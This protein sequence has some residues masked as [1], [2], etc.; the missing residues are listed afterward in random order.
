LH[1]AE[2]FPNF[3]P[4][5]H[6]EDFMP[7]T[8]G[9]FRVRTMNK[10]SA[11]GLSLFGKEYAV[12]DIEENP[13]ALLV[14]S[15]KVDVAEHAG[16]AAVARAGAGVN[17]INVDKATELGVCVFNTPGAN[18]NAVN[19]LVFA[20]LSMVSRNLYQALDYVS[21]LKDWT[22]DEA[23]DKEVEKNKARFAG[24]EL[25]GRTMAIVGLGKIGVLVAN[26]AVAR[27][28]KVLA[29][30]P[31]PSP[32]NMHALHQ[33]VQVFTDLEAILPTADFVSVHVP[34]FDST[35]GLF[36]SS[37]IS[38]MKDDAILLN[39]SRGPVVDTESVVASLDSGKL[40]AYICDFPSNRLLNHDKVLCFP[41]L[42]ASTEEAEENCA[43]MA[44]EQLKDYLHF[45]CVRNS[46]NFPAIEGR[47]GPKI[48]TRL[49]VINKDVPNMIS[50]ISHVIAQAGI[51]IASYKNES[52]GKVGYNLIDLEVAMDDALVSALE[53]HANI[54]KVR[55]LKF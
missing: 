40:A 46:V 38:E 23:L 19:E 39:F 22:D 10:I 15:A 13:H 7:H 12:S 17:N 51:N 24:I 8:T 27:G 4:F 20:T 48:K 14:R 2:L 43:T 29:Y 33:D 41:H 35:R 9:T 44:V 3:T 42:G 32:W 11:K 50:E 16:L 37:L 47:P 53:A 34:L 21:T 1:S 28:L 45:G 30:E 18:A 25:A 54:V 49:V 31:Y 5:P 52:N 55:V 26:A 36:N 6:P